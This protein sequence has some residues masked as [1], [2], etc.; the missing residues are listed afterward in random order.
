M[1]VV[2]DILSV[3]N[4]EH[5]CSG[6]HIWCLT[7]LSV[8]FAR[9]TR[10][11]VVRACVLLHCQISRSMAAADALHAAKFHCFL[12]VMLPS[13]VEDNCS[14]R[15]F[16]LYAHVGGRWASLMYLHTRHHS[17]FNCVSAKLLS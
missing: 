13:L 5:E 14:K 9:W 17:S 10:R 12:I 11:F 16:V 6:E 1:R 15:V 4:I 8:P 3:N 2:G 7:S